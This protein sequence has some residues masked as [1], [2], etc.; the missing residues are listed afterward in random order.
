VLENPDKYNIIYLS[1]RCDSPLS[2]SILGHRRFCDDALEEN[3]AY[4]RLVQN[5]YSF[6]IVVEAKT[7]TSTNYPQNHLTALTNSVL[8]LVFN[9]FYRI[10]GTELQIS[11]GETSGLFDIISNNEK[12]KLNKCFCQEGGCIVGPV[13]IDSDG[14][15][16]FVKGFIEGMSSDDVGTYYYVEDVCSNSGL[17][18]IEYTCDD[19]TMEFTEH[20]CFERCVEGRCLPFAD[21]LVLDSIPEHDVQS[22]I[23][24]TPSSCNKISECCTA[25]NHKVIIEKCDVFIQKEDQCEHINMWNS[26][27][28]RDSCYEHDTTLCSG[29]RLESNIR[30]PTGTRLL[31]DEKKYYCSE[32]SLI[33]RQFSL[34]ES[35]QHSYECESNNCVQGNCRLICDGCFDEQRRCYPVGFRE[36]SRFCDAEHQFKEQKAI[37]ATCAYHHECSSNNCRKGSCVKQGFFRAVI[38]WFANMF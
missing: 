36:S 26:Q 16:I 30:A 31:H 38:T 20:P 19:N 25:D 14:D 4:V 11:E 35:C 10:T 3:V 9:T 18:V 8:V 5:N 29:C 1:P 12:I 32:N 2:Q 23:G 27:V 6:H 37:G 7:W 21:E 15:D 24:C 28:I 34:G 33:V 17:S 13:C 22:S